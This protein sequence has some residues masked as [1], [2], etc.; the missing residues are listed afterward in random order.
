MVKRK[1]I[2]VKEPTYW[3]LMSLKGPLRARTWDELLNKMAD[4]VV[5]NNE[6]G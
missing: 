4:E 3:R 1:V 5:K 2:W 6:G